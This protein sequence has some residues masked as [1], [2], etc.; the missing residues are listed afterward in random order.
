MIGVEDETAKFVSQ[1]IV[2][3][4]IDECSPSLSLIQS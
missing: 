3:N 4:V 2:G 1:K